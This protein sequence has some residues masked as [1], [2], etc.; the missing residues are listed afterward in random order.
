M[1]QPGA[2]DVAV[3]NKFSFRKKLSGGNAFDNSGYTCSIVECPEWIDADIEKV[4]F[5]PR[6]YGIRKTGAEQHHA[7][8]MADES[9]FRPGLDDCAEFHWQK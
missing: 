3:V 8:S 9:F 6:A 2:E 7:C 4:F 1:A 5:E